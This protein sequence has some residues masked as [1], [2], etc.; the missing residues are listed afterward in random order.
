MDISADSY[1]CVFLLKV[2]STLECITVQPQSIPGL[3]SDTLASW[4]NHLR[5]SKRTKFSD[6]QTSRTEIGHFET[7]NI[8]HVAIK[9][10]VSHQ[11]VRLCFCLSRL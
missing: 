2:P 1:M 3:K 11:Q 9:H 10:N 4:H 8:S 7:N 6:S 5:L